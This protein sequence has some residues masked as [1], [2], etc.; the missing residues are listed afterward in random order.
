MHEKILSEIELIKSN[1][2]LSPQEK[3]DSLFDIKNEFARPPFFKE[4]IFESRAADLLHFLLALIFLLVTLDH[5][6]IIL[7][8]I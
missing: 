3:I 4:L 7:I 1:K 2:R 8:Q 6:E 5:P